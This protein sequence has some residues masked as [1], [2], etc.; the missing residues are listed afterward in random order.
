MNQIRRE[1]IRKYIQEKGA[2]S[3]KELTELFPDVSVM[4]IHRDLAKLEEERLI[5]RTR[6]G[7][8]ALNYHGVTEGKLETRMQS[9][10]VEKRDIAQKALGLIYTDSTV[11]F[12]AG[13]SCMTLAQALPDI[14]LNI[15]TTAPNIAV[16]LSHLVN[17]TIHMCGGT[18]NRANQAVSGASTLAML[19]HINIA[20]AFI[21]VSGYTPDGGFTCGKED[22][23]QVKRL[24]M[25]KAARKVILM[26][27]SKCGKIFPYMF[28]QMED[29]DYVISDGNLPEEFLKLAEEA[30][31]TVL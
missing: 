13:T 7:A 12:D 31:V 6:G 2:V 26:D 15:F 30:N 22:E 5:I 17:P 3:I 29:V 4:T 1:K 9:N 14:E 27:S 10:V 19:E 16:Q 28:G 18:L 25:K 8:M 21:G 24:I 11:F 23:M 20:T